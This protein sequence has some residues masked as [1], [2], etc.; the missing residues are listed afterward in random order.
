M[1]KHIYTIGK[2]Y[3]GIWPPDPV[4]AVVGERVLYPEP[5]TANIR[6]AVIT[7]ITKVQYTQGSIIHFSDYGW[8]YESEISRA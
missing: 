5:V 3:T 1:K 7:Y 6:S 8:C 4:P 2:P